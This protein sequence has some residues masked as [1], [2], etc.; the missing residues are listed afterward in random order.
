[1]K[2]RTFLLGLATLLIIGGCTLAP[3]H[4]FDPSADFTSYQQWRWRAP[5]YGN[6]DVSDPIL[7]SPLLGKR[8]AAAV[9]S[10]LTARGFQRDS[11]NADF[12]VT[13][14]TSKDLEFFD[15]G[16]SFSIGLHHSLDHFHTGLL[17]DTRPTMSKR[18]VLILDIIDADSNELVWRG[19]RELPLS[20]ENFDAERVTRSVRDILSAFPPEAGA[21]R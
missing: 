4:E 17:Y 20:Q 6:G 15:R 5:D 10:A 18:G 21:S 8:V 14:H 7:D 2:Y 16:P 19:W 12:V 13:Y 1:M 3:R 9:D 11:D